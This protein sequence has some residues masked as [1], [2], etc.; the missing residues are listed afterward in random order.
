MLD[1]MTAKGQQDLTM[2]PNATGCDVAKSAIA[3]V[4]RVL[5]LS[6]ESNLFF[7]YKLVSHLNSEVRLV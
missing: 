6:F 5:Q 2:E 7:D 1:V 3:N 4:E